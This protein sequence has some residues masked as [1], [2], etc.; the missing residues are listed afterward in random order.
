LHFKI[1]VSFQA[2]GSQNLHILIIFR[3][4]LPKHP[5]KK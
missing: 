4:I 5:F 1:S 2:A 3:H